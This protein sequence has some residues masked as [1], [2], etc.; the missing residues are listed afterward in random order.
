METTT[1]DCGLQTS[2]PRFVRRMSSSSSRRRPPR[3]A[4]ALA[5]ARRAAWRDPGVEGVLHEGSSGRGK[6][7]GL[8]RDDGENALILKA[9]DPSIM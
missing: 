7:S 5:R 1:G 4:A 8:D 3:A 2:G 9:A 6:A